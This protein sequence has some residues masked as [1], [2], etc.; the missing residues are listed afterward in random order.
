MLDRSTALE[1]LNSIEDATNSVDSD[2]TTAE[3]ALEA[4]QL[5][6]VEDRLDSMADDLSNVD[7]AVAW[8]R[9]ALETA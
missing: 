5:G 3:T 6:L 8:L 1:M 2:R 9:T 7:Y 4:R